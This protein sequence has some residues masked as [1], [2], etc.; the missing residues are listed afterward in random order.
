MVLMG[1]FI[2]LVLAGLVL[3]GLEVAIHLCQ[4]IN[5]LTLPRRAVAGDLAPGKYGQD[6]GMF[7]YVG[8]KDTN[9]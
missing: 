1:I 6:E 3:Y 5:V 2:V 9:S 4:K 8:R 7:N